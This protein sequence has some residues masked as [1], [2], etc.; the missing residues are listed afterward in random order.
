MTAAD[1]DARLAAPQAG[2]VQVTSPVPAEAW[3]RIAATDPRAMADHSPEW[4]AAIARSGWR[5]ASR[6]YRFADGSS[7][8]L[9]LL[10]K[11]TRSRSTTW[12]ASPPAGRGFGGLV[13]EGA[14]E[15]E[16]IG[17]VLADLAAQRWLSVRVRPSPE[18]GD[19]WVE[20]APPAARI[21]PRCAHLIDL[22]PGP[23]VIFATM[24]KSTR[25]A[26]RRHQQRPPDIRIG[27]GGELLDAYEHLR[28]GSIEH[29]AQRQHEPLWLARR[30]EGW[31][32]P[33]DR[34]HATATALGRRFRVW[35]ALVEGR[36]VAA[37][38][39]V[40]GPTAHAI[41]AASDRTIAAPSGL[42]Q[43]LDWLA[44]EH[45]CRTGSHALNLGESGGSKSLSSYKEGLGAVA[46]DYAE[47]RIERIP[48][49]RVDDAARRAVKRIIGFHEQPSRWQLPP[50]D[51]TLRN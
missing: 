11:A 47:I 13:G 38:V 4:T 16:V 34:L 18:L 24:R 45:A 15:R 33:A 2:A 28:Q 44:I 8:V 14:D 39:V 21:V 29:W 35:V 30:R 1:R 22:R 51:T 40:S 42:M 48:I 23:D 36:P 3:R 26:V 49:T 20:A 32:S 9:P 31:R 7:V 17:A 6:L 19:R 27:E 46:H 12:A 10:Q 50:P 41:R 37:N 5:D 43:Y 25:R